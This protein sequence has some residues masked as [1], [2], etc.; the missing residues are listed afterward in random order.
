M[1]WSRYFKGVLC[2]VWYDSFVYVPWLVDI[3]SDSFTNPL[4]T[5]KIQN[6]RKGIEAP[7]SDCLLLVPRKRKQNENTKC[8]NLGEMSL[9]K[10]LPNWI[11][12]I[13]KKKNSYK[14][15]R[16]TVVY[17]VENLCLYVCV[18]VCVC[19]CVFVFV[20]LR[21]RERECVCVCE[22]ERERERER[23]CVCVWVCV[24]ERVCAY[25]CVCVCL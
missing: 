8:T 23:E 25:M 5:N 3:Y 19:V 20:R 21:E 18:C 10:K 4:P 9:V 2:R 6:H 17:C 11:E 7:E 12:Q 22:G 16:Q 24:C 15:R 13:L 1:I 14:K